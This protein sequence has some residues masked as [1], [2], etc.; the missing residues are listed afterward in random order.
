[1]PS[2]EVVAA[3]TAALELA[4]E[5]LEEA[6]TDTDPSVPGNP[7]MLRK[8]ALAVIELAQAVTTKG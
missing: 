8:L 4:N 3:V 7:Q 5:V 6:A 1:M 2:P